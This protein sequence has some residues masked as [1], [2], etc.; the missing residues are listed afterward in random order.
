MYNDIIIIIIIIILLE[1]EGDTKNC[2]CI[3][4]GQGLDLGG[5]GKT[6]KIWRRDQGLA[7]GTT[8]LFLAV[9]S[10]VRALIRRTRFFLKM[11]EPILL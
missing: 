9:R 3:S 6:I 7:S 10:S 8:S 1:F 11:I 2:Y 4:Q 5:Q